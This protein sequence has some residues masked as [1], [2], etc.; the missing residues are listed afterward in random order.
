MTMTTTTTTTTTTAR[1]GGPGT[2]AK[3]GQ[4]RGRGDPP[5]AG[6][7]AKEAHALPLLPPGRGLAMTVDRGDGEVPFFFFFF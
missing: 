2:G 7:G 1:G 5:R 6:R 4:G 3:A